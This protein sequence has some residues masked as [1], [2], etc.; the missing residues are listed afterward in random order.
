M[1]PIILGALGA[2][3]GLSLGLVINLRLNQHTRLPVLTSLINFVGGLAIMA[4]LAALGVLGPGRLPI[5]AP[6]WAFLG[7]V[8]GAAYV[9]LTLLTAGA[10]GVAASTAAVTLGQIAGARLIDAFGLLGQPARPITLPALL[11]AALLLAAVI[12]LARER[13]S[14]EHENA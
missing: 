14:S 6:V 11:G 12:L 3:F 13:A 2:G 8:V 5:D 7:G 9:T 1:L 10:L 4:L